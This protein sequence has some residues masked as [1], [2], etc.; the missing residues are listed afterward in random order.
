LSGYCW[1]WFSKSFYNCTKVLWMSMDNWALSNIG[2]VMVLKILTWSWTQL[3]L[4]FF[5]AVLFKIVS[6]CSF[7]P[8]FVWFC[9]RI[10]GP[11][12]VFGSWNSWVCDLS[13]NPLVIRIASR[14]DH[15]ISEGS[16]KVFWTSRF[17][18]FPVNGTSWR[19]S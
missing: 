7:V 13:V 11:R 3:M 14:S 10:E 1:V 4:S 5:I 16:Y 18:I 12:N 15:S 2:S 6:D 8:D 9:L 19:S 17:T